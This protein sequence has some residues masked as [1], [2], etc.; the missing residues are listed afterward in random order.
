[1]AAAAV[2]S[3]VSARPRML[4]GIVWGLPRH[5]ELG[6][7]FADARAQ[8]RDLFGLCLDQRDQAIAG[9]RKENSE[10]HTSL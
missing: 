7:E 10:V 5:G 1:M 4:A 6:F 3:G 9:K 8:H 2:E